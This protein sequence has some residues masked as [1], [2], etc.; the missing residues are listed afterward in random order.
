MCV[1]THTPVYIR[2]AEAEQGNSFKFLGMNST[3]NLTWTS[4]IS[5]SVK[6][7]KA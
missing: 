1:Y 2:G 4:Y 6:E 3:E 5:T 7:K